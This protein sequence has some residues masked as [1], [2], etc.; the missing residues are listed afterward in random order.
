[1]TSLP[2][3]IS[4][5]F[6]LEYF[7]VGGVFSVVEGPTFGPID[8]PSAKLAARLGVLPVKAL[9]VSLEISVHRHPN[10]NKLTLS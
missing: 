4:N 6:S 8:N 1:M 3:R 5:S 2:S 9:R 10:K 7:V